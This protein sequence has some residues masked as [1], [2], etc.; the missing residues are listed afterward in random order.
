[1]I[2][3]CWKNPLTA[4]D[5][6][7]TRLGRIY[8]V[9]NKTQHERFFFSSVV[10]TELRTRMH[11]LSGITRYTDFVGLKGKLGIHVAVCLK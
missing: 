4:A 3:I 1:M 11:F 8:F 6:K 2:C 10:K 5:N 7:I 9:L